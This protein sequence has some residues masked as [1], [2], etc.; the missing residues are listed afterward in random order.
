M[1]HLNY[2][3]ILILF[4][5]ISCED[6]LVQENPNRLESDTYFTDESSLEIYTN[7]L[8]RSFAPAINT[9]I[10]GDNYADTHYW[11]GQYAYFTDR[12]TP[13]DA[14]NWGTGNWSQL[15]SINYYLDNMRKAEAD[16]EIL[17]HY[18]GV[19][20]FF[21]AMFYINKIQ[22]FGAVPWYETSIDANDTEALFKD[23]DSREFV[24]S[25]ILEDL[26]YAATHCLTSPKYRVKASY[27]HRYNVY[28][29]RWRGCL[30]Q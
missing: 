6:F 13:S 3:I 26:N 7:G 12:Y 10:N 5:L 11:Q 2:T 22:T 24:A 16:P 27:I 30:H 28:P 17:D 14:T 8:I 9:F 18:E 25:K 1:K 20:R 19:G 23:R 21:R 29:P 15:R 4:T